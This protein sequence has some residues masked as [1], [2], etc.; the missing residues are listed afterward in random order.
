MVP[1]F[2]TRQGRL[3]SCFSPRRIEL[4]FCPFGQNR[5]SNQPQPKAPQGFTS[6]SHFLRFFGANRASCEG[7]F[8]LRVDRQV[9]LSAQHHAGSCSTRPWCRWPCLGLTPR[10]ACV[11]VSF[12]HQLFPNKKTLGGGPRAFFF[13]ARP[14]A[15]RAGRRGNSVCWDFNERPPRSLNRVCRRSSTPLFDRCAVAR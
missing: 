7:G 3:R 9:A 14:T 1:V 13:F 6:T 5:S 10:R 15:L 8:V 11:G 2:R 12:R 4:R